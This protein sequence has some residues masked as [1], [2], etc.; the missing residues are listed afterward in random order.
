MSLTF[1]LFSRINKQ[2]CEAPE[3][4]N[5]A[6]TSWHPEQWTNAIAG[7]VG[8]ACN[9]TKKMLRKRQGIPGNREESFYDLA[10][11]AALEVCDVMIYADL[12]IQ[13]LGFDTE[14][15][16]VECFNEK[17]RELVE[18]HRKEMQSILL[19]FDPDP[20]FISMDQTENIYP[21]DK[22]AVV[23]GLTR[24]RSQTTPRPIR[25]GENE[26]IPNRNELG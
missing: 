26:Q 22:C 24:E 4:F 10:R 3:G 12:T 9:L 7:E 18:K 11:N 5:H 20:S 15:M 25:N 6:L 8:E 16:L 1:K 13:A 17:S 23:S 2:R 19:P 14:E 21:N